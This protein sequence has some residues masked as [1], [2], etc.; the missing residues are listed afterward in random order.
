M[1]SGPATFRKGQRYVIDVLE[2][3]SL[4]GARVRTPGRA[5]VESLGRSENVPILQI[6]RPQLL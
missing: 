4:A 2:A 1:C 3:V 6:A 5:R